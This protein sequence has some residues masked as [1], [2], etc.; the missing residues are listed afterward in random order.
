MIE[1]MKNRLLIFLFSVM[2]LAVYGQQDQNL[3]ITDARLLPRPTTVGGTVNASFLFYAEN[4]ATLMEQSGEVIRYVVCFNR[5][6]AA[7]IENAEVVTEYETSEGGTDNFVE[8][9][10]NAF[11]NCWIGITNRSLAN[12][13]GFRVT[14]KNL[15]VARSATPADANNS[16]G[17][18]FSI[19]LTPHHRDP[20]SGDEDD[21]TDNYTY[22]V[23]NSANLAV[24]KVVNNATPT[25]G[26]NVTFTI[27]ATNNGPSNATGVVVNE[28]LPSGYTLV[29]TTP[30]TGTWTAPNWTIGNLAN[31]ATA[32]MT[33]VATVN[34]TGTYANT[35][36]IDGNEPDPDPTDNTD[37]E[38]PTPNNSAN[39]AVTKV[40]NNATP[41]VGENVTFTI[42]ATNNGPSNATGV[43]VNEPLPSG[44]TLV[45]TTPSTGTYTAPNWTI[46]NLAN[47]ATATMTVVATVNATGTYAN[48]VTIDG[49]E[50]DPDPTDNTDTETPTPNN[51]ANLAVT[52][53]VNNATPTVGE[54]VT[55]TITATNNGPSNATGVVVNEPLPSG[56]TLVSTTPSTGTYTAPN[57]T[58]GNL[59]NGATATMTVVATVNA[60]GTYANT[61]TIDGN[62]PDPDPTDNTDTET[63]IPNNSANLA[64]TKVVN[65]ATPTVGENV[66][67]TITATNNGPSNATGVV[68][69][70]PLPSGYTFVSTTPS[71]GTYTAPNWTIGNLANGATAT[72]TVVATVNATGTYANTV[73]IDGNEP[74]PDPTDNTDTETPTPKRCPTGV[75]CLTV[76]VTRTK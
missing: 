47:G 7:S 59:A 49:N 64:I 4:G 20:S 56:Y 66:T 21:F 76:A 46:G 44:Y 57:W 9:S 2:A 58:I 70:E 14:F 26:E 35:V 48:T 50:P 31:G 12:A 75:K 63:P 60:T 1:V 32:T 23:D 68:V 34:A 40:V 65:N 43:V 27:T 38:T 15:I 3:T 52:K 41:T 16:V 25:V 19:N 71:T 6:T 5:I 61:V 18:G 55:F 54:N 69:N 29:S 51:S 39:L 73:T 8:W 30:S 62:E 11:S 42:T 74:D 24:T 13:S 33:V 10:Y 45:S 28:P 53:V 17:I 72:M 37:T 22:T 67:F 36:T